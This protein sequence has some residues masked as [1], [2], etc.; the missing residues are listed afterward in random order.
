MKPTLIAPIV[1]A[2]GDSTRMGFPKA[3]L[4]IGADIFLTRILD[5]LDKLG[6]PDA[7]TVLGSDAAQISSRIS[8]RRVQIIVNPNPADGQLSSIKLALSQIDPSSAGCLVWPVDQ[9]GIS[10]NL[11]RA[12]IRLFSDSQAPLV[13]PRCRERRGH[14]AIFGRTLFQEIMETPLHDGLKG[15]IL[16]HQGDMALLSTNELASVEDVDTPEDYFRF[17]GETLEEALAKVT[18]GTK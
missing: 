8:E 6:L 18:N 12:L 4:P 10:E 15:L 14:P 7:I 3:L 2:A 11:V 5:T 9:P 13:L 1:L 16:R 17:V